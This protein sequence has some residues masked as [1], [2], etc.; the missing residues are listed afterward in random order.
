LTNFK[1]YYFQK[2]KKPIVKIG[3]FLTFLL[4][5]ARTFFLGEALS[6]NLIIFFTKIKSFLKRKKH[7]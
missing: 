6:K 7:T 5:L 4:F 1:K 2:Q 3:L